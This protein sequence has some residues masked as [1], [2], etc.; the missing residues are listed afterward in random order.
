MAH[1]TKFATPYI[2]AVK[3]YLHPIK[4]GVP[5]RDAAGN[6]G[7]RVDQKQ[8]GMII[9]IT[10]YV[11]G[12]AVARR[13]YEFA[14]STSPTVGEV[15]ASA[16]IDVAGKL[17]DALHRY[18][19]TFPILGD[20][21]PDLRVVGLP[22]YLRLDAWNAVLPY[23][24]AKSITAILGVYQDPEY[25]EP[26]AYVPVVFADSITLAQR[27][28]TI[29]S[30]NQQI[31]TA[32]SILVDPPTYPGWGD[33]PAEEQQRLRETAEQQKRAATAELARMSAQPIGNLSDLFAN[34]DV[35]Q[36][37]G[38]LAASI[39]SAL[40]ASQPEWAEIDVA[41]LMSRFQLPPV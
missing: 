38:A 29:E 3:W 39:F 25:T 22:Y 30:L 12:I 33:L 15:L 40:K 13:A 23:D 26:A 5:V 16:G 37:I 10:P 1:E 31:A 35:Q 6:Q 24:T 36:A 41:A 18:S 8:R 2:S 9:E 11:E 34:A 21:Q 4:E 32:D 20:Q 28:A 17:E 7:L 19:E 14:E 27:A